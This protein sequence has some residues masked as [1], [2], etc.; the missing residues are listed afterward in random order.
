MICSERGRLTMADLCESC[1]VI[2]AASAGKEGDWV[3][4][5]LPIVRRTGGGGV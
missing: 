4:V 1:F 5:P 2:E 3:S